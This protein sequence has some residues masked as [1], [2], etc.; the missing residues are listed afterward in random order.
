MKRTL[1]RLSIAS[2][3]CL[4]PLFARSQSTMEFQPGTIIE[5]T[6]GA[7]ICADTI[8]INGTNSV[9]GTKC[10]GSYTSVAEVELG[11]AP[12]E[13]TLSQNYPNPF[14]PTT[15]IEFTVPEDGRASVRIYDV[16]GREVA[17]IFDGEVKAGYVQR[18]IF[19]ASRLSTGFYFARLEHRG[20]QLLK[21]LELMK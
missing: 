7:D 12:K 21:K 10:G 11:L 13:F 14:N 20:K 17:I 16:L 1:H 18:A 3:L 9:T 4:A 6:V 5:V 8:I 19:D 15:N 2:A